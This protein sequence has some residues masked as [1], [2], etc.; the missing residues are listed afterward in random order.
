MG[1]FLILKLSN[2]FTLVYYYPLSWVFM[3]SKFVILKILRLSLD[4][5]YA[6]LLLRPN[7]VDDPQIF[8]VLEFWLLNY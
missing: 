4:E 1:M 2:T 5:D 3:V 7:Y 6:S 8:G